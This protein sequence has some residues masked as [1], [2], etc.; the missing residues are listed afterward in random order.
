[1]SV[2]KS[3]FLV[4]HRE[5]E[6]C[7]FLL[8][9]SWEMSMSET[10]LPEKLIPREQKE[11]GGFSIKMCC[12]SRFLITTLSFMDFV[13]WACCK[14]HFTGLLFGIKKLKPS[15]SVPFG[16]CIFIF[17]NSFY[18]VIVSSLTVSHELCLPW[19]SWQISVS[20]L[21]SPV[22]TFCTCAGKKN[23]IKI[24]LVNPPFPPVTEIPL[25]AVQC[26]GLWSIV[27]WLQTLG[28]E[29]IGAGFGWEGLAAQGGC[30]WPGFWRWLVL[31]QVKSVFWV[32]CTGRAA[33]RQRR[34][35]TVFFTVSFLKDQIE[36]PGWEEQG[37]CWCFCI[38][39]SQA[40]CQGSIRFF[41]LSKSQNL[42]L[43]SSNRCCFLHN[44]P[45]F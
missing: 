7:V 37:L 18:V 34:T 9:E 17:N 41:C 5:S 31:S 23:S 21:S 14:P 24:S 29:H 35:M 42:A 28:L 33:G 8:L 38:P 16:A 3:I 11:G 39:C 4:S 27:E 44:G 13:Q 43:T 25:K 15:W 30:A 12:S 2:L 22:P 36:A 45:N 26:R 40:R 6:V 1:M 19:T 32:W 20:C 10:P